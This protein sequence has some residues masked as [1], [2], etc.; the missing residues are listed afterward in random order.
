MSNFWDLGEIGVRGRASGDDGIE[1]DE[2]F[3]ETSDE[4]ELPGFASGEEASLEGFERRVVAGGGDGSH[5]QSG[6]DGSPPTP[7]HALAPQGAGVSGERRDADEGREL[8]SGEGAEL[9]SSARRVKAVVGP[10]PGTERSRSSLARQSGPALIGGV[11]VLNGGQFAG[12]RVDTP[13]AVLTVRR[14]RSRRFFSAWS[15]SRTC[16]GVWPVDELAGLSL[17]R[18]RRRLVAVPHRASTRHRSGLFANCPVPARSPAPGAG[19]P[20]PPPA[21]PCSTRRRLRTGTRRSPRGPRTG[22]SARSC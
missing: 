11:T 16:V 10:T 6:A 17:E 14:A 20:P 19:S 22:R 9:G 18:G 2:E 1:D 15:M 8:A 21:E 7:N 13:G 4:G 5:V 3:A 12:Q